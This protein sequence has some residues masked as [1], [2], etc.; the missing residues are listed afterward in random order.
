MISTHVDGR[1]GVTMANLHLHKDWN[2]L[3]CSPWIL[4]SPLETAGATVEY[5]QSIFH[6][7]NRSEEGKDIGWTNSVVVVLNHKIP[8]Q[9]KPSSTVHEGFWQKPG[10]GS[11]P[12]SPPWCPEES[13]VPWDP[14][15]DKQLLYTWA[16]WKVKWVSNQ[17]VG[18]M[19]ISYIG[20]RPQI[21]GSL[22]L[23]M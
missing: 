14:W 9:S 4:V 16:L 19:N 5:A 17:V 11:R 2:L 18:K 12:Q 23:P 7:M 10:L 1:G 15:N 20:L 22:H 3:K 8:W 21:L 13:S 6:R